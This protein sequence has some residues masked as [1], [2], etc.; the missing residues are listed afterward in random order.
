MDKNLQPSNGEQRV[1]EHS[2]TFMR[3]NTKKKE[4]LTNRKQ[5]SKFVGNKIVS[6][7]WNNHEQLILKN[8]ELLTNRKQVPQFVGIK[9]NLL[10]VVQP[11]QP[12]SQKGKY[13]RTGSKFPC[14]L[15]T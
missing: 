5:V 12:I 8:E 2:R 1:L 11:Q 9:K 13:S 3:K 15:V 14:S 6:C 7:S 4:L 10:L